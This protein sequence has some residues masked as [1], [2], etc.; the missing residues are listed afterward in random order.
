MSPA[1]VSIHAVASQLGENNA[2]A[3]AKAIGTGAITLNSRYL[4]DALQVMH[5]NEVKLGF[6]GKIEAVY[7]SDPAD[8]NY[9]HIIM[10]LKS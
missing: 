6:N 4:L 10:P 1:R 5:G 3:S 7:I 8:E 2:T 9:T